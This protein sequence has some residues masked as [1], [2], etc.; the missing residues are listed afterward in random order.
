MKKKKRK[1][2]AGNSAFLTDSKLYYSTK[3]QQ[4][5]EYMKE[6]LNNFW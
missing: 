5:N 1:T 2:S 3:A 4:Y 6:I